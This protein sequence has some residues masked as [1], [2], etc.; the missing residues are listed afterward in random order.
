MRLIALLFCLFPAAALAESTTVTF[1]INVRGL[2]VASLSLAG[3]ER[4]GQYAAAGKI[5]S[6]GVVG[7]FRHVRYDGQV[8]GR[9][10]GTRLAPQT[11]AETFES[12]QRTTAKSMT[13]R[14]GVPS[15]KT[16]G[17]R[18]KRDLS[19]ATQGGTVDPLSAVWG[20]LRDVTE[21]QACAF[22]ATIFD[23]ARRSRVAFGAPQRSGDTIRCAGE[24]RRLAGYSDKAMAERASFP[25]RMTYRRGADDIWRVE[26]IEME[27]ILGPGTMVRR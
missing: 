4:G 2:R 1:D 26:R 12:G 27:S 17:K 10:A 18:D 20:A 25:F 15:L 16:D 6:R 19:P 7:A 8:R 23:G 21:G 3:E 5:Q 22:S 9:I 14:G 11:Y 13:Y 24:Y